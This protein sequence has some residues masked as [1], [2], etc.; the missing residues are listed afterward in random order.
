MLP[1]PYSWIRVNVGL[2]TSSGSATPSPA[3][4]PLASVVLPAPRLPI[5]N[6]TARLGRVAAMRRPSSTVSSSECVSNALTHRSRE[7]TQQ[8]GGDHAVLG[9]I[10]RRQLAR[11]PMQPHR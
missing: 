3:M 8:V 2:A 1:S 10:L 4:I 5:N 6:T 9:D 7:I 11:A